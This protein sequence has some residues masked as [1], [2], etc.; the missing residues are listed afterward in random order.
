MKAI[1]QYL[2]ATLNPENPNLS[3]CEVDYN[4]ENSMFWFRGRG[5]LKWT[6]PDDH[7][8]AMQCHDPVFMQVN[9]L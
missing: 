7:P 2:L 5:F 9:N 4:I 6:L 8:A 3:E 1:V